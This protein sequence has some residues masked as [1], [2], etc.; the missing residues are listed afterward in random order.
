[1]GL[2]S[3]GRVGPESIKES[4]IVHWVMILIIEEIMWLRLPDM[5]VVGILTPR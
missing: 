2:D 5:Y 3:S 1:M 4:G